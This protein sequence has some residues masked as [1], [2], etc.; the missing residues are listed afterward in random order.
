MPSIIIWSQYGSSRSDVWLFNRLSQSRVNKKIIKYFWRNGIR[1]YK[2]IKEF[3]SE[4]EENDIELFNVGW[5]IF[6]QRP[7]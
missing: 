5:F 4:T 3:K 1:R 2:Q 7:E 6:R